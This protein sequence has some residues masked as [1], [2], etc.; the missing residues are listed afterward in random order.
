MKVPPSSIPSLNPTFTVFNKS[1]WVSVALI[2]MVCNSIFAND[3]SA[4][5]IG[6]PPT[7][8]FSEPASW[9]SGEVPENNTDILLDSAGELRIQAK[10]ITLKSIK[11]ANEDVE[12]R[13]VSQANPLEVTGNIEVTS[14]L[15]SRRLVC[16]GTMTI[17]DLPKSKQPSGVLTFGLDKK[18][19]T[20]ETP[21]DAKILRFTG[22]QVIRVGTEPKQFSEVVENW[23]TPLAEL[24]SI[25]S[26]A[27]LE[28]ALYTYP[29]SEFPL[30]FPPGAYPLI[31]LKNPNKPELKPVEISKDFASNTSGELEWRGDILYL[32]VK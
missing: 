4:V 22:K 27:G 12:C 3:Q 16:G 9:K 29:A 25:E 23:K 15:I 17:L 2:N 14:L 21:L 19:F 7:A 5:F 18:T 30:T 10:S 26:P 24:D 1:V 13:L 20:F 28:F 11:N 8:L 32:V 6:A 31:Q